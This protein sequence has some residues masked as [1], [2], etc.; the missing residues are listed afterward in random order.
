[1]NI[2]Y[3]HYKVFYFV[4]HEGSITAAA[5]ALYISQPA[6]S[7]SITQ[8][9]K[10]MGC[11]LFLRCPGGM[12]LTED[13]EVLYQYVSRAH[14]EIVA[15]EAIIKERSL[16]RQQR[17]VLATDILPIPYFLQP[18]LSRYQ[19][20]F[21]EYQLSLKQQNTV[22]IIADV[23][24]GI[25]DIGFITD[26]PGHFSELCVRPLKTYAMTFIVGEDNK[27]L[28][29]G[30]LAFG[31]IIEHPQDNK[32]LSQGMLA[33]GE[34][35]E[36][37]LLYTNDFSPEYRAFKAIMKR[38]NLEPYELLAVGT[39]PLVLDYAR[40]DIGIGAVVREAAAPF[41]ESGTLFEI[42]S[43]IPLPDISLCAIF[44]KSDLTLPP[45]ESFLSF[46]QS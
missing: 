14:D 46:F 39:T 19:N 36:H 5:Q 16:N 13:G 15:G 34:I 7:K 10:E 4:A 22:D 24:Q 33:F 35:I 17:L 20:E 31:E 1:M 11:T 42:Q 12:T 9:E 37:P 8:L 43:S 41:L 28:S 29:Q 6:V 18:Y 26:P 44:R 32:H 38:Q 3:E 27:H 30:M 23:Q 21:P 45:V 25:V 2:N 40:A